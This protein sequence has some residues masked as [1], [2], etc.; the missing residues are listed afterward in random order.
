M[1]LVDREGV[2]VPVEMVMAVDVRLLWIFWMRL[3]EP[4]VVLV[5]V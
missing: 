4:V 5:L 2:V 1:G 3:P